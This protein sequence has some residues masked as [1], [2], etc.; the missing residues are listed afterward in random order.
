MAEDELQALRRITKRRQ[1]G[2]A[3]WRTEIRRLFEA[4]YSIEEIAAAPGVRYD[5]VLAIIRPS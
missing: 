1:R 2:E 5:V 3:E 4:G